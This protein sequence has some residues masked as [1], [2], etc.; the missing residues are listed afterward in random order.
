MHDDKQPICP[1]PTPAYS[2][3]VSMVTLTVRQ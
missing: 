1:K 3:G 2:I